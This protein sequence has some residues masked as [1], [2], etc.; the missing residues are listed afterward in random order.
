MQ[1][2]LRTKYFIYNITE[3]Y[4]DHLEL[5]TGVFKKHQTIMLNQIASI[6]S[7]MENVPG[8]K[9]TTTAGETIKV[10]ISAKDKATLLMKLG[11]LRNDKKQ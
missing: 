1:P 9:I 2:I 3:L 6:E 4:Q 10:L 7:G 5:I 8:I 11:E